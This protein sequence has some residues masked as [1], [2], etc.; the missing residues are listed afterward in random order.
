VTSD[1]RDAYQREL[2]VAAK[3]LGLPAHGNIEIALVRHA[4]E[5]VDA[6]LSKCSP[7]NLSELLEHAAT[8]LGLEIVEVHGDHDLQSLLER[9]PPTREPA[10]ARVRMELD[11]RT[12][13]VVLQ[14]QN[15]E[16][17][18]RRYLAVIN[19][20]SWHAHRR[21]FSKWHEL[22]HLLLEGRQLRL[23]FRRTSVERKHPEEILVDKI[24]GELAFYSP[25]FVPIL[26]EE[27]GEN[28]R[29][30]FAAIDRVRQR[31][32]PEASWHATLLATVRQ[33]PQPIYAIRAQLGL[34]KSEERQAKDLLSTVTEP[35]TAKLRVRE[36][37][38]NPAAEVLGIRVHL[39][40][41]VP[42]DSVA[43]KAFDSPSGTIQSGR[44]DLGLWRTSGG[45]IGQGPL[46]VEGV[47]RGDDLWCLLHFTPATAGNAAR[48]QSTSARGKNTKVVPPKPLWGDDPD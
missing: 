28:R 41:E 27:I 23:E 31:I 48:R 8:S 7:A 38:A 1:E 36:A 20:R 18:E 3:R 25:I 30:T 11:D 22:V 2:R 35:P 9:I 24:A 4:T 19:C 46:S 26:L 32:A 13:A 15:P 34:K 40:M 44:E 39:N 37:I 42:A 43:A 14:R 21:Y 5:A 6:L 47:R 16:P 33:S 10:L 17:W 45:P 29:L 12:D